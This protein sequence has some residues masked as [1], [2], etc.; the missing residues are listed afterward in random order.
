MEIE[1]SSAYGSLEFSEFIK[2]CIVSIIIW[3]VYKNYTASASDKYHTF[4]PRL[5]APVIDEVI[6]WLPT[7][8]IPY[9]GFKLLELSHEAGSVLF[10]C[11]QISYFGYSVYFHGKF[12]A[13]VG[14][15]KTK[16][17]VVDAKTEGPITYSQA[18]I[19][20][21]VPFGLV[22]VLFVYVMSIGHE[23]GSSKLG[24]L[25]YTPYIF[26]LWFLA[27]VITMFTNEKRRALHDFM[28]GTVIVRTNLPSRKGEHLT[29]AGRVGIGVR[30]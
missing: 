30:E 14:K 20:D 25:E 7:T 22:V 18:L 5:W 16:V 24:Y 2:S 21:S 8:L 17:K 10:A 4:W 27:E 15:M 29:I 28:A 1:I 9:L 11:M 23:E 12:G 26:L 19:R 6:L 3:S 13:T